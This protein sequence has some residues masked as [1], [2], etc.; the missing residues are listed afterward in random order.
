M[1]K[2]QLNDEQ[3]RD[4]LAA[5]Q[6]EEPV[7]SIAAR[8]GMKVTAVVT[9]AK[10]AKVRR[11][12]GLKPTRT[13]WHLPEDQ[14]CDLLIAYGKDDPIE[15]VSDIAQRFGIPVDAVVNYAKAAGVRR[16]HREASSS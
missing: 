16:P 2:T 3:L 5:Y 9:C 8:F 11:P 13:K 6:T 1:P 12:T 7:A 10:K 15:D 14:L 4:L